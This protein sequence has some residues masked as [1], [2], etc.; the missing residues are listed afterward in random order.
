MFPSDLRHSFI[1][2]LAFGNVNCFQSRFHN[3][4]RMRSD[5]THGIDIVESF[6]E[7]SW[8]CI[9]TITHQVNAMFMFGLAFSINKYL[10]ELK[11]SVKSRLSCTMFFNFFS[12]L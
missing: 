9:A 10:Q 2:L 7:N 8:R 5:E 11:L 3:S 1:D 6:T 12:S 4:F